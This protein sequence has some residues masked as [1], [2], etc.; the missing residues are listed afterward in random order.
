MTKMTQKQLLQQLFNRAWEGLKSQGFEKSV[1]VHS[2]G[3]SNRCMYR[4]GTG[5]K[6]AVGWLIDDSNYH[7]RL[8]R[9]LLSVRAVVES[10]AV[11]GVSPSLSREDC[12]EISFL[13]ALQ[14]AH[15]GADD[16]DRM[17]IR[18][19]MVAMEF[20][21]DAPEGGWPSCTEDIP[22]YVPENDEEF[23]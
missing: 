11:D 17:Q 9:G 5:R 8:D 4:D 3:Y 10:G 18:L 12:R 16:H 2:D 21:L 15:D 13:Q 23:E 7:P 1:A 19:R 20:E 22:V 14:E 6:C